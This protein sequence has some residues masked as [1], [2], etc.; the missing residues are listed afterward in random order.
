M[1][2]I[3]GTSVAFCDSEELRPT[4]EDKIGRKINKATFKIF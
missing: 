3:I 2:L 1:H 4:R